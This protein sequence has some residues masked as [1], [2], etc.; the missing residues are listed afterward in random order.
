MEKPFFP[1]EIEARRELEC[2]GFMNKHHYNPKMT[3]FDVLN[4]PRW[5]ANIEAKQGLVQLDRFRFFAF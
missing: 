2:P 1:T 3:Q 4:D 5:H